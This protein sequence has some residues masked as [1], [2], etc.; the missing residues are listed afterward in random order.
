M[1]WQEPAPRGTRP[2]LDYAAI[3]RKLKARPG[4]S[5]LIGEY[6]LAQWATARSVASHISRGRVASMRSG[7]EGIT[8]R[9]GDTVKLYA[10]YNEEGQ[11]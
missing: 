11:R 4:R 9:D 7:F 6:P 1:R 8:R 3:A 10:R 5:L 2:G